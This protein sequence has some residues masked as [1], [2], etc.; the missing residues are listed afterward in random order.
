MRVLFSGLLGSLSIAYLAAQ[1]EMRVMRCS[2]IDQRDPIVNI[3]VDDSNQKWVATSKVI[4]QVQ[5]LDLAQPLKVNPGEQSLMSIWGGNQALSWSAE[6]LKA[7]IGAETTITT[8]YFDKKKEELWIGTTE[9]GAF[10]LKVKPKLQIINKYDDSNSKLQVNDVNSIFIDQTGEVWIG[11]EEGALVG[12]GNRWTLE[13]RLLSIG[14]ITEHGTDVWV[15]GNNA[16]WRVNSRGDWIAVEVD[17]SKIE[18]EIYD[19]ALDSAGRVWIAS[20]VITRFDPKTDEYAFFGP[21]QYY[22]SQLPTCLSIDKEGAVWVGTQDKGLYLIEKASA[23]TVNIVAEKELGCDG[24]KKEAA[25]KVKVTGGKAPFSYT[26]ADGLAGENPQ[27]LGPGDY[28]VT[29]TDS[30][31]KFKSAKFTIDNPQFTVQV[32]QDKEESATGALDGAAT[33]TLIGS[34]TNY[35]FKWDNGESAKTAKKLSTGN[36][37]VTVTDKKG[38]SAIGNIVIGQKIAPLNIAFEAVTPLRCPGDNNAVVKVNVTG[39]KPPYQYKWNDPKIMGDQPT[40]LAAGTY[41]LE[42]IDAAG[43]NVPEIGRAHV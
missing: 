1:E 33:I 34:V 3:Y 9:K 11:T 13:E 30:E 41:Q 23:M 25:L 19:I 8:A 38:C 28:I 14:R 35:T 16:I 32:K 37:T 26:W 29:V 42:V 40:G 22:T 36:H 7:L 31:G 10:Q 15:L 2:A 4:Y 43:N 24:T 12:K 18:G 17:A 5:A 21:I 6:E 39:G 20:E 27:N